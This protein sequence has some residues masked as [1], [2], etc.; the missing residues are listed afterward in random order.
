MSDTFQEI[1][2][3]K[4]KSRKKNQGNFLFEVETGSFVLLKA[5]D[6]GEKKLRTF[7]QSQRMHLLPLNVLFSALFQKEKFR[8]AS[9][10]GFYNSLSLAFSSS[11]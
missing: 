1:K 10:S 2:T 4:K 9:H 5:S 3:Q 7:W 8:V 11:L 6:S